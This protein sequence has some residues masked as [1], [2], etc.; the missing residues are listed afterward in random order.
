MIWKLNNPPVRTVQ[1]VYK[2]YAWSCQRRLIRL[3]W[4]DL[5]PALN[6]QVVRNFR[7]MVLNKISELKKEFRATWLVERF[8]IWRYI[9]RARRRSSLTFLGLTTKLPPLPSLQVHMAARCWMNFSVI[10]K[11]SLQVQGI[12]KDGKFSKSLLSP[13]Q[14]LAF[15]E[16]RNRKRRGYVDRQQDRSIDRNL[17]FFKL[18]LLIFRR[19]RHL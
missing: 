11:T 14:E 1:F 9:H 6:C 16:Y 8:L 3:T 18:T 4:G 17:F 2:L 13:F 5:V 12:W 10:W 19:W 15:K 7:I